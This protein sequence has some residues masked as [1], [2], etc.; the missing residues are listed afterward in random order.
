MM[1]FTRQRF[2]YL[3][4]VL[5][6]LFALSCMQPM[7]I[8]EKPVERNVSPTQTYSYTRDIKPVL[9]K[10]CIACHG[11][12]DAPC[13]LK[14]TSADG[15][16]RGATEN[17]VYDSA[18]LSAM[19][20]TR[21][22]VDART[23]MEWREK[24]FYGVLNEQGGALENNLE[25]SL[26]FKM[27]QL[28]RDQPLPPHSAVPGHIQLGLQRKNECPIPSE[29]DKYARKKPQQ[30][31]P[32]AI[33]GLSDSE[34][35]TLKQWVYEGSVIDEKPSPLAPEEL[36][37]IRQW[38]TY[39][40]H[41]ALKNQLVSRYLYEHLFL[42]HVYFE[43]LD[44]GNFFELVRSSAPPGEPVRII[45]TVRPDDDPGQPF[46]YRLRKIDSTIVYKTHI[47]YALNEAKMRRFEAL[48]LTPDWDVAQLPDYSREHSLNPFETFTAIPARA[49]YQFMLDNAQYIVMTFIRGPVCRGQVATDVIN[50]Q[51]YVL[52]QNPDA[53]LSVTDPAYLASV[54]PY[55]VLTREQE[56]L[57]ELA[58]DWVYRKRERNEYIRLRGQAYRELQPKGPSLQDIWDGDG[59]NTNAALTVFRHFDNATVV[60]G[61]AGA[62][63]KTLW[64]MDYPML[65][66]TYYEL[67]VNFNV[68]GSAAHQAETRLYFDLIRSGGENNFLHFMPADVRTSMRD[69]WYQG[70]DA[71]LKITNS[72][73]IVNEDLPVQIAYRTSDPKAEFVTLVTRHLNAAAGPADDLNRCA[74]PPC[75]R[76]GA[77]A[78]ERKVETS[79]QTLASK[80]ASLDNMGFVDFMPDVGFLR[81]STGKPGQDL[82]YTLVRNKAHTNVAFMLDEE[83]RRE[84]D[85]DTL[86]VYRGLLGSYPNFM[87]N[88]P[89]DRIDAFTTALHAVCT[90]EHFMA[91]V[92]D[93]GIS[94]THPQIWE[95]FQWFVDYMRQNSPVEAGVYDMNRY[96]KLVDLMADETG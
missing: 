49:R 90:R 27:I 8:T 81:V 82:A 13:Q 24:D 21:L 74:Q 92:S 52:F 39:F 53:D 29:F 14:L 32:L 19:A 50:D 43:G 41:A 61:F 10:K 94:R 58:P 18:R 44:S 54:Q 4:V 28:G 33:A 25:A 89:L 80:P 83:T 68:F 30:G 64:V 96:R 48:F 93:Y 47:T 12:Y 3:G 5:L 23:T 42:A 56:G 85:K 15:L 9:E 62:I 46:Y 36:Q 66:R 87:F 37:Q 35:E 91:L 78:V 88:V 22:F 38:E 84:P 11:C 31:M 40:N 57:V 16:L 2:G 26:L 6:S 17:P 75:Y 55:L 86:T 51:F 69:S 95:N 59:S 60:K 76:R 63:P 79:L 34:Y 70:S 45:P 1:Q 72:Y 73:E 71:Q 7:A 67:V 20:P 77:S 65:E